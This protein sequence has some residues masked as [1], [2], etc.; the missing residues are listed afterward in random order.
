MTIKELLLYEGFKET[1]AFVEEPTSSLTPHVHPSR[2]L[3]DLIHDSN[4][5][6]I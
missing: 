5:S 2:S 4:L 3:K 1:F 6:K